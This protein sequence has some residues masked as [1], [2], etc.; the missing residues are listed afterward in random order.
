MRVLASWI[1]R[2]HGMKQEAAS[3][4][5]DTNQP[6]GTFSPNC[7]LS[8]QL[9]EVCGNANTGAGTVL[10][11]PR[12]NTG[13]LKLSSST[14]KRKKTVPDSINGTEKSNILDEPRTTSLI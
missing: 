1:L 3:F 10:V 5:P 14:Q 6:H 11:F 7:L 8:N 13:Q 9:R 2:K 4:P 12:S